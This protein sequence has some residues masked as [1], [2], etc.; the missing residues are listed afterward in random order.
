[1]ARVVAEFL[2]ARGVERVYGLCGGHILPIWDEAA[3][4]GIRVVD[5]RH[6]GAALHM[7]HAEAEL[8]GRPGVA[9]ATAGPG[10][11]N[12][13][14]G[15][16]NAA[17]SRVPVVV[18]SGRVP[19]PQAG[20]GGLQDVPQGAVV[21]PLC[22]R[23]ETVSERAHVLP[24]LDAVWAA[25]AGASGFWAGGGGD[26]PAGPAYIDFPT[27]LLRETMA[28]AE[29]DRSWMAARTPE[30]AGPDPAAVEAAA[31]VLRSARRLVVISGRGARRAGPAVE[32]FLT[33]TGGLYL[34]TA[35]SRGAVG[36]GHPACV[37]AVRG[38]VMRDA[39]TVVTLERRLD[40]QLAYGSRAVFTAGDAP[41]PPGREDA[42]FVRIGLT[43]EERAD[44]RRAD[45]ELA[46]DT[47]AA[48][49]ALLAAG[50]APGRPDGRWRDEV[51]ADNT[52]RAR[53]LAERLRAEEA[54]SDGPMHPYT[55]I[56]ALNDV[57]T[58]DSVVVADG[59]DIL[60]FARVA[61]RAPTWLDPGPLGCLGVGTPF[62]VAAALAGGGPPVFALVG[63]GSFGFTALEVD[64]AVRTGARVV[65]VVANN[66]GWNIERHDQLAN[67]GG[68]LVGVELPGC[69]YD[70]LARALGAHGER[71]ESA[72]ELRQALNR[73]V[74][75][76]PAVVDVAVTRQAVS[77]DF[78]GGLA[79]VPDRQALSAWDDAERRRLG[80]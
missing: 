74:E 50:C 37:P 57:I 24:R 53:R 22:R 28:G 41:A 9:L 43:R 32:R 66:G 55:L 4:L 68:R 8:T 20:L 12:S 67:Y 30:R 49:E 16:A 64:T 60:S 70:L 35:E 77:P 80:G 73:A 29:L 54:G 40:F 76:A 11:T 36:G 38:R 6:E 48:L 14:T 47:G 15:I 13:V 75:H 34:D 51:V 62:A 5:V 23:V 26:G 46:A 17:A 72:S 78:A 71:V 10:L 56:A 52:E 44:N 25:A 42:R 27:D 21:A 19:R 3:Q 65:I 1:V 69:R 31:E 45:V 58:A 33:A 79:G 59:G 7:A 39:D 61:L 63:D 2:V 18:I